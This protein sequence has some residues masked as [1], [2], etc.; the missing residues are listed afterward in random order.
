[1]VEREAPMVVWE[2]NRRSEEIYEGGGVQREARDAGVQGQSRVNRA[3]MQFAQRG[4]R[5]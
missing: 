2:A 3:V 4:K 5:S 1:M